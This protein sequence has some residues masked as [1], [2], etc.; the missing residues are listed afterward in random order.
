M[1]DTKPI[2]DSANDAI[3]KSSAANDAEK[4]LLDLRAAAVAAIQQYNTALATFI[5]L[6]RAALDAIIAAGD[7]AHGVANDHAGDVIPAPIP[8]PDQPAAG[9]SAV[10]DVAMQLVTNAGK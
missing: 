3:T 1:L 7:S 5:T 2:V 10:A 4:S 6:R 8:D 9:S